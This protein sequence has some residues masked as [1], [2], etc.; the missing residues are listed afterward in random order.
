MGA[1]EDPSLSKEKKKKRK[2]K[3]QKKKEKNSRKK[4]A[5]VYKNPSPLH[6]EGENLT[7][8]S[9][10]CSYFRLLLVCGDWGQSG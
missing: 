2:K 10:Y 8:E 9:Y 5:R 7:R 1:Q 6:Q 3:K 4:L